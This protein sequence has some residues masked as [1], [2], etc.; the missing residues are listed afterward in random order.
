MLVLVRLDQVVRAEPLVAGLAFGQRI[1][2]LGDVTAGLPHLRSQDHAGIQPDDVVPLGY[3][4]APPLALDVVLDLDA[5]RTVI[6]GSPQPAVDLAGRVDNSPPLAQADDGFQAVTATSHQVAPTPRA[7]RHGHEPKHEPGKGGGGAAKLSGD[8]RGAAA[9]IVVGDAAAPAAADWRWT[10]RKDRTLEDSATAAQAAAAR[11][12]SVH[13]RRITGPAGNRAPQRGGAADAPS[14]A[15]LAGASRSGRAPGD[16]ARCAY[17]AWSDRT[18]R[19]GRHPRLAGGAVL[20]AAEPPGPRAAGRGDRRRARRR[21]PALR[22]PDALTAG[23]QRLDC[24]AERSARCLAE[25]G[26]W[27]A[28]P[29]CG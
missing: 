16:R 15:G 24:K 9:P 22:A 26:P 18:C 5:E 27:T 1:D 19:R 4:R 12:Q 25:R 2:E 10:I 23:P 21:R 7:D 20:A 17:L 13:A 8:R 11:R 29:A 3:H 6:P 14:D 28:G